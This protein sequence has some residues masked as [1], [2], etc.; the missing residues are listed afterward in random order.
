VAVVVVVRTSKWT[1]K[2]LGIIIA[3]SR[4]TDAS[5]VQNEVDDD[6]ARD[7]VAVWLTGLPL[8]LL[9]VEIRCKDQRRDAP[10][11]EKKEEGSCENEDDDD[12]EL[13]ATGR[14]SQNTTTVA[15]VRFHADDEVVAAVVILS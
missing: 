1:D 15:E 9:I 12:A 6:D 5:A 7:A 10:T 14:H 11:Q 8:L 4:A 3:I 2:V 13:P